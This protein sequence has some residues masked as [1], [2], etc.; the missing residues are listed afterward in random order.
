M[1][2]TII[3]V[4]VTMLVFLSACTSTSGDRVTFVRGEDKIDI[5]IDGKVFTSYVTAS[6]YLGKSVTK[7]ILFPVLTPAGLNVTRSFPFAEVAGESH[8]HPHHTGIFFTYDEVSGNGFWNNTTF[9]PQIKHMQVKNMQGGAS[10]EL[11]TESEWIGKENVALLREERT[12]LFIPGEAET[13]IDFTIT[14]TAL[15]DKVEF[16]DTKEGMFAIRVAHPL[17]EQDFT[18]E[19][20]SSNGDKGEKGVWGKRAEWVKLEGQIEGVDVGIAILNHPTSTNYPTF[21]HA[22]GYGLFSAN[23]LGQ[24][25]FENARKVENPQRFG[26]TLAKGQS[27]LF[28]FRMIIYDG[29]RSTEQMQARFATYAE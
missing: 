6:Q 5:L 12:M 13:A 20:Q 16:G 22:R 4:V 2:N 21:W 7:P 26:L 24:F 8:D 18:G 15:Q 19:Y 17:Q 25:A 10:G 28:K 29:L 3:T 11:T 1:K 23:P 9:P 14:L 27:A